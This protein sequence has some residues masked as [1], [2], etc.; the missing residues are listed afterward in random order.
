MLRSPL[1]YFS[2]KVPVSLRAGLSKL[3][4]LQVQEEMDCSSCAF[5]QQMFWLER[6]SA[7]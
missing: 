6:L 7:I 2:L 1:S 5:V 3:V 4:P